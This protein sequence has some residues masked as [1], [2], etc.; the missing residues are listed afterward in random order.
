MQLRK[1][2]LIFA[3]VWLWAAVVTAESAF[4][5]T[6]AGKIEPKVL[7]D[8]R[9]AR[10]VS[11]FVVLSEQ[12]DVS[13]AARITDWKARGE[14]V[15]KSLREH[16]ARTQ[17]PILAVLAKLNA[18]VTPFWIVN[19]IKVTTN[20][21]RVIHRLANLPDVSSIKAEKIWQIPDPIIGATEPTI[22]STEWGV[23]RVRAPDVW[24]QYGFQGQGIVVASID[25]GVQY[26]HPALVAQYRGRKTDGTFDHNY[27]WY[28]PARVC[29]NPS[30]APCDN[31]GHGTHTMGT[32]VG[33][34]GGANQIGVAPGARWI[35][36]K[37]CEG[38]SCSSSSLLASGQWILAPTDLNGQN[39]RP[40]LR[41]NVVNNSWGGD[42]GTDTFFR[43]TIQTWLNAG[44]FPAFAIGNSGSA[45][46]TATT[47]GAFPE[48]FGV[49]AVDISDNIA[50]FSGRGPANGFGGIAKPNVSAPGV[51][52]RSSV[53]TNGYTSLNGTSMATPHVAGVVALVLSAN[54]A[55]IGNVAATE[56]LLQR[57]ADFRSGTQCGTAGPPNNVFGWGIVNALTAVQ[58][59]LP[60]H[61]LTIASS[62]PNSGV[63]ITVVPNDLNGQ[64]SG[65]TQF[66]RTYGSNTGV[67]LTAP[68][69]AGGKSF[70]SWSG[71]NSS[72]G[73]TCNVTMSADKTVTAVYNNNPSA[74]IS[75]SYDGLLRDRVGQ[76]DA[77]LNPDGKADGVFT[78]TLNAGSGTRTITRLTLLNTPGGIWNTQSPDG[79][80][81]LGVATGLDTALL[82]AAND[83]VNFSLAEG[84]SLKIF[85][86]DFQNAMFVNGI[87][88][89]LTATLADG[90]SAS[91]NTIIT[92]GTANPTI[93]LSFDGQLRDRVGQGDAS[94]SPDG[95]PD[96][97]FTVTL[98]PGSG[99]RTLTQLKLTNS[100][101]GVWNT[102]S[103]DGFWSLGVA[104]TLDTALLNSSND[105]V[106]ISLSEGSSLKIFA[107][108]FQNA[109]F[110]NGTSFTLTASFADGTS[111][112]ANLTISAAPLA[113]ISLSYDGKLRDRVGQGESALTPDGPPDGTF[114][115]TLNPGSGN[116]T[117]ARLLLTNGPGGVWNTQSPDGFWTLGVA[118][119]LDTALLNA[120]N[121]SINFP[122]SEGGTFKIFAADFQNAMF[123][124]GVV[125]TL[126]VTFD[127]GSTASVNVTVP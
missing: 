51:N 55:L 74:S 28:D 22:Q 45:C 105:S 17:A 115:V 50:S 16:A 32:A 112:N 73:T 106:N 101:G 79:F 6:E 69:S 83:S 93:S 102:Q 64:G 11:F 87:G 1:S 71:C 104:S 35:S 84:N 98:I 31:N 34:D 113:S 10:P 62:N 14:A 19:A 61:T 23:S 57:T 12:A 76:N 123:A 3:L 18:D 56:D 86:A 48:A 27:N 107:A 78:V 15:V 47:P 41:P 118:S 5:Q 59:A 39:P 90:S 95:K 114:T 100:P 116:R 42:N 81:S 121:D 63:A 96:G 117:V 49:G 43:T 85:A 67:T 124:H 94:L 122:F 120:S 37:C 33:V 36:A 26:N 92:S 88:F 99:N 65:S 38:T 125:F 60:P 75:I 103:P 44:I 111:A 110:V 53:P 126:A 89:A 119:G 97:V 80:W 29:G 2:N 25:T 7:S 13:Y 109:M 66:T 4:S 58:N 40:D 21:E 30:L 24:S 91:A 70:S 77:A 46:S 8:V 54:P 127:D 72:Q 108:D 20:D 82:N 68:S 52:I 9:Q